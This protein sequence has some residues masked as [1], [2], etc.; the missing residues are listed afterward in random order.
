MEK[1]EMLMR[2]RY[3]CIADFPFNNHEIGDI[4]VDPSQEYYYE[5]RPK[6]KCWPLS[7]LPHLFKKLEWWED[8]APEDM[9]EYVKKGDGTVYKIHSWAKSDFFGGIWY[10]ETNT[11]LWSNHCVPATSA[12]YLSYTSKMN[13]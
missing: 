5:G 6:E 8:R 12:D 2:P 1:I 3:K 4:I 10:D 11:K 9:P 7:T 13:A